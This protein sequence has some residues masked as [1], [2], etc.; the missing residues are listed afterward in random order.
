MFKLY[1]EDK[2]EEGVIKNNYFML[3]INKKYRVINPNLIERVLSKKNQ[4]VVSKDY[5]KTF[6]KKKE[7][8]KYIY[9]DF[10]RRCCKLEDELRKGEYEYIKKGTEERKKKLMK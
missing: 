4:S 5:E 3:Y 7:A 8:K 2:L 9:D 1:R 10:N 6:D